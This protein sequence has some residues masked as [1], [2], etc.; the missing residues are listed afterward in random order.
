MTP[1]GMTAPKLRALKG[2][3]KIVCITAYDFWGAKHADAAGVDVILVGDSLGNVIQGGSTTLTVSLEDIEYHT[4]WV[5][6]GAE[7][8]LVV[9]DLPF[10][11]Y[12]SG[13]AG[14]V[15]AAVR[16]MKA[17]AGSVKLEGV[18]TDEI[19]AILKAGI[20][21]MGHVG[22]TP[23]SVHAFGGHRVQGKGDHADSILRDAL[24]V[25]EAGCY[26]VVL[27][28]VPGELA[29]KITKELEIPTIGI[30]AGVECDGQIQVFHDLLGI[31]DA[32][33][34]HIGRY[35]NLGASVVSAIENYAEE[36]RQGKFPRPENTF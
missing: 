18:Y 28:L 35:E 23:Q 33:Y 26:S 36:V 12:Q 9:A 19:R 21:V 10:G 14:A 13:V 34:K 27:E 5:A 2:D 7:K 16:L 32:P 30:G 3:R 6:R 29:A 22:M 31:S 24:A 15:D 25:Q 17:G 8:A 4:R 11:S 20:P 1:G